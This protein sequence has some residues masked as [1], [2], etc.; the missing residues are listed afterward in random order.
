[1]DL[2]ESHIRMNFLWNLIPEVDCHCRWY[3]VT[4][5]GSLIEIHEISRINFLFSS[6]CFHSVISCVLE[7]IA[8]ND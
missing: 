7:S 3:R 8:A 5:I 1:M 4:Q 6:A 2:S